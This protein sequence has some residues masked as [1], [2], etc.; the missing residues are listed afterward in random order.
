MGLL[1]S[2]KTKLDPAKGKVSHLAQQ[3][4]GK[5]Q[6]GLD[7]AARAVDERTKGKYSDRIQTGTGK[8]KDAMD[9]LAHKN[10]PGPDAG[11]TTPPAGPPPTS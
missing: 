11:G 2:L 8:A 1:D 6:H 5:I 4:G 10:D 7:K 9:R 3:H